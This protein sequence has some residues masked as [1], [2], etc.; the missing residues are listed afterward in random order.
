[1]V[2]MNIL[3]RMILEQGLKHSFISARLTKETLQA[4]TRTSSGLLPK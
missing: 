3:P 4:P 2:L 1:M